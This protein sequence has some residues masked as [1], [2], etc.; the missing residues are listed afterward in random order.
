MKIGI[1]KHQENKTRLCSMI[2]NSEMETFRG[3]LSPEEVRLDV[4]REGKQLIFTVNPD[5]RYKASKVNRPSNPGYRVQTSLNGLALGDLTVPI[6]TVEAE[7]VQHQIVVKDINEIFLKKES[8]KKEEKN[9]KI[10]KNKKR[11]RATKNLGERILNAN[12]ELNRLIE[13]G[14][15]EGY[16]VQT[17]AASNRVS[18]RVWTEIS[19]EK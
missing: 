18:C 14:E 9:K 1:Y 7:V 4:R 15:Q 13:I 2:S 17:S 6:Q 10:T 5:G 8:E 3:I 16:I 11:L 12:E 19:G